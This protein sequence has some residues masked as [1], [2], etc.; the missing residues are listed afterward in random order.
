[1]NWKDIVTKVVAGLGAAW[2]VLEVAAEMSVTTIIYAI[3]VGLAVGFDIKIPF[4]NKEN[5]EVTK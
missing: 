2:G 3:L 5:K 4:L 1:M